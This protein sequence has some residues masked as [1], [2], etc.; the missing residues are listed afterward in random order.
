MPSTAQTALAAK[1]EFESKISSKGQVTL[2][3]EIRRRL[4]VKEGDSVKFVVQEG[5]TVV[6]PVREEENPFTKWIG[7]F[8][9][10]STRQEILDWTSEMRDDEERKAD[11]DEWRQEEAAKS[12]VRKQAE[13]D[14][15]RSR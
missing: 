10:F 11:L 1:I 3:V 15:N 13:K 2:P 14:E 8:P 4:G 9:A 7:A 5:R 12:K 6:M